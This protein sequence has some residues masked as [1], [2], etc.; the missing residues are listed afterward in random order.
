MGHFFIIRTGHKSIK[1]L[2]QQVIQT[3]D[4]QA[5]VQKLLG[6]QFRIEYKPGASNKVADALSHVPAEWPTEDHIAQQYALWTLVSS[7]TFGIVSQLKKENASDPFL[8][9]FHNQNLQGTLVAPY[10]I[11]NGLL[12]NAGRY[13]L[14]LYTLLV[15]IV[16]EDKVYVSVL[17]LITE[18][19]MFS[20]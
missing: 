10:T 6:F 20:R 13:V 11:V 5:H 7:P 17:R 1:E 15:A 9:E 12:L 2:L 19:A 4:Q 16:V 14:T 18:I 8:L 3:P